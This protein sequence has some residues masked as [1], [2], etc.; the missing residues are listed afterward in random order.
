MSN[1]D[2][3]HYMIGYHDASPSNGYQAVPDSKV[4]GANMGPT[5]GRQDPGGPHVGPM[6]FAIWGVS[7]YG[8][9]KG[10]DYPP[11]TLDSKDFSG[12]MW[13]NVATKN[14]SWISL[15][16]LS[17]LDKCHRCTYLPHCFHNLAIIYSDWHG[18][19]MSRKLNLAANSSWNHYRL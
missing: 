5:W 4:Y 3:I 8:D 12:K 10:H 11:E 17:Q 14:P 13:P 15:L 2:L 7:H 18:S 1:T 9:M 6:N 19:I 16:L